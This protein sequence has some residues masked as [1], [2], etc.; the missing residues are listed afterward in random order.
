MF[1]TK[2]FLIDIV[3]K[4]EEIF[5]D[6]YFPT[7]PLP[8]F[9]KKIGSCLQS[10]FEVLYKVS[11]EESDDD[12][13]QLST[14]ISQLYKSIKAEREKKLKL[15]C[16]DVQHFR[17]KPQLRSYQADA[18]RWMLNRERITYK[19]EPQIHPL[20]TPIKLQSGL[21]IF[22]DKYSGSIELEKP[23]IEESSRGGILADEMGL[24]KTV[25]VLACILNHPKHENDNH[26]DDTLDI[27]QSPTVEK[28][29]RK[30]R[31]LEVDDKEGEKSQLIDKSKKI[32]LSADVSKP[33]KKK[34]Q[35]REA[36]EMW[37][38]S[39]LQSPQ[40]VPREENKE[41]VQCVCGHSTTRD[42]VSCCDCGK[43]QHRKCMG[44]IKGDYRCPQC[45][46]N[47]PLVELGTTLIVSPTSLRKQW[48]TEIC[49]HVAGD[50]KV[51][52]YGGSAVTPVYPTELAKYDIV[53]TTY[54][55]LQTDLRLT[56]EDKD[57][58]LR[59]Q[60]KYSPPKSPL[61]RVK[62]WRLCLD[63]AQ[64]VETPTSKVSEMA[65]KLSAEFRWAVTG[66]PISKEI[67]GEQYRK[68]LTLKDITYKYTYIHTLSIITILL[69]LSVGRG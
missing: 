42:S 5:F 46:C 41:C 50:L 53:I 9:N 68:Y 19:T 4:N 65:K 63:E 34:S 16:E 3:L 54:G 55:V 37:Y 28:L 61:T 14:S 40:I 23:I 2:I 58:S 43:I 33:E 7:L 32:K 67:S 13:E 36:L 52:V 29:T 48:C 24:G 47:Q 31:F 1:S 6:L 35:L 39:C 8:K 60:R 21:E 69:N 25:E 27:N 10:V 59:Y 26:S 62:W 18:V 57:F 56:E 20:Y 11:Y 12:V 22:F 15:G 38:N 44:F 66:T 49:K 45:W 64:T 30:R 17:L 51:L